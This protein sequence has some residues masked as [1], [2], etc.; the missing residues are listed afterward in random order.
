MEVLM[1]NYIWIIIVI[2]VILM[3]IIGYIAEK[4]D[5]GKKEFSKRKKGKKE[6]QLE[7]KQNEKITKVETPEVKTLKEESV[8]LPTQEVIENTSFEPTQTESTISAEPEFVVES[9]TP[10][11]DNIATTSSTVANYQEMAVSNNDF[12]VSDNMSV[13]FENEVSEDLN[14]PFGDMEITAQEDLN[15][16]LETTKMEEDL[17]VPFGE[18]STVSSESFNIDLPDIDSIKE[19]VNEIGETEED[20]IWKF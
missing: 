16:P 10:V 11:Y 5:F 9:K 3:T 1:D 8:V 19:D 6:I 17:N 15:M 13:P 12:V 14:A 7:E 4:T 18:N 20:D 2:V